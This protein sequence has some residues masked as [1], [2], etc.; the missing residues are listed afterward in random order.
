MQFETGDLKHGDYLREL[1]RPLAPFLLEEGATEIAIDAPGTV[2]V[3]VG[4]TWRV[5]EAPEI[6]HR[7]LLQLAN[8]VATTTHQ[9]LSADRPILSASL[10]G[11]E[12]VQ[13]LIPPAVPPGCLTLCIRK[14]GL[15]TKSMDEYV[16]EGAFDE[17]RW[18]YPHGLDGRLSELSEVDK[19]LIGF[20]RGNQLP[21]FLRAA[22]EGRKNI[23]VVGDTGSGK[24]TL[25]KTLCQLIP[26]HERLVTIQDVMELELPDHINKSQLL[27]S[28][29]GQGAA[30][31]TPSSLIGACF[32]LK[33]SRVLMT[34]LRGAEA[35]DFLNLLT[36]G[37]SG[38]ITSF[39]SESTALAPERFVFMCKGN[40]QAAIYDARE[41]KR[42]IALTLDVV[43]HIEAR[44]EQ[45]GAGNLR[46]RRV[47]TEVAFDPLAKIQAAYGSSSVHLALAAAA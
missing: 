44:I 42:L 13:V 2:C 18:A 14:P 31:V 32:R 9:E 24:T 25:M 20:L 34:E 45:D 17:Y 35:F 38:S 4:P 33:P 8:L 36:S 1:L 12:R 39:H 22:V 11:G 40:E 6:T 30:G 46:K 7:Y 47:V 37:H 15:G 23:A 3:E 29:G 16:E 41:L 27:Y 26:T 10:P 5:F 21:A 43:V 19:G 28:A